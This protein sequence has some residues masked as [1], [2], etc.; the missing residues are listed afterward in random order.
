MSNIPIAL[1]LYSLRDDCAKDL[2]GTLGDVAAMGYQAVEFAG[3]FGHDAQTI[4]K[5]L[6]EV[7]LQ[8][9][10]VHTALPTVQGDELAKTAEF[11]HT[12]GSPYLVI[13]YVSP[14]T[15]GGQEGS[16]KLGQT[17]AEIAEEAKKYGSLVGYHNHA[18]EFEAL[19]SGQTPMEVV[20][21]NTPPEVVF[22]A[23]TGNAQDGGGNAIPLLA[24]FKDRAQTVHLKPWAQ[25]F[26]HYF[27]G[28]DDTP[29][30]EVFKALEGGATKFYIVE[31]ERYPEPNTP[32]ECVKRCLENLK[33]MG[34]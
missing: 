26:S 9:A 28:E 18:W 20:F 5:R 4:R 24:K 21:D 7:G 16:L 32:K 12:L 25:D 27:L 31:Q 33:K 17:L 23:D 34:I 30:P 15:F 13:P 29:W 1:Q 8:C 19:P 6:D 14:D 10:G 22:Q 2:L 11:V 3:Y